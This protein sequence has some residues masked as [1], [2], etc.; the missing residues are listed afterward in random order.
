MNGGHLDYPVDP[1]LGATYLYQTSWGA[2]PIATCQ[3]WASVACQIPAWLTQ[4]GIKFTTSAG[5]AGFPACHG[6]VN[7]QQR[8][9]SRRRLRL[10]HGS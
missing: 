3:A 7:D 6:H 5:G 1:A 9:H 8:V 10:L 2:T 4:M